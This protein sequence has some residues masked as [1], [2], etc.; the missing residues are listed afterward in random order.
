[1]GLDVNQLTLYLSKMGKSSLSISLSQTPPQIRSTTTIRNANK[2]I[3]ARGRCVFGMC[4]LGRWGGIHVYGRAP[5]PNKKGTKALQLCPGPGGR[6]GYCVTL[7]FINFLFNV[8]ARAS[9]W[10]RD[11]SSSHKF[12]IIQHRGDCSNGFR[13]ARTQAQDPVFLE[14]YVQSSS[15]RK[16][17]VTSEVIYLE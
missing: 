8:S 6:N 16:T 10:L 12:A 1:M 9:L 15:E 4:V 5:T 2:T 11:A 3:M 13:L 7:V 14:H 17:P